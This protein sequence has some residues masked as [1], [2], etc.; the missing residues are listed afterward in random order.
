M[1]DIFGSL[2]ALLKIDNVCIDNFVFRLHYRIT[3]SILLGFS[4]IVTSR[5]YLGDPIDCIFEDLPQI[6]M[7]TYCWIHSTF[8]L[9][10]R[11]N[12]KI[13][14][15]VYPGVSAYDDD[16]DTVK[17]HS[18]YQWVCF[19]LFFQ[20]MFFYTPRYLWKLWEAGRMSSLVLDLEYTVALDPEHKESL[21]NYF[22][23]NLHMQNFYAIR[24]FFCEILNLCNVLLQIYFIDYFL[25]GEFSMYG[26][27]VLVMTEMKTEDRTD[28][29]SR[30]FPIITKCTFHKYGPTGTIQK[31]D[32]M[33]LL[34]QN[35]LNEKVFVFLWFW[36]WFIAIIS[37]LN[38]LYRILIITIPFFRLV[39]LRSR[40]DYFSHDKL[41]TLTRKFWIG[42]WFV[43]Y[44]LSKN[45]SPVNF[46]DL[47]SELS[48]K[49][50]E[51][52]SV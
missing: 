40:I 15:D 48:K 34:P 24:F 45:I 32:G 10:N 43:F 36:F 41:K 2:K 33:C 22:I 21:I 16:T 12:G 3:V 35:I 18:Y 27:N 19:V 49:F 5:Q 31:F 52:D 6:V 11:K 29:M 44:Q 38:I 46:K 4:I 25:E 42:D 14:E 8:T 47:V 1:F 20:A 30:V 39:L 23:K 50:E 51:K 17:Y 9:P 7:D 28:I 13:S 37:V 26:Y